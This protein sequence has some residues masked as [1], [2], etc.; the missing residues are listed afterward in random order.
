MQFGRFHGVILLLLGGLLLF[1]QVILTLEGLDRSAT[2]PRPTDQSAQAES[3]NGYAPLHRVEYVP[4]IVGVGLAAL[5][6]ILLVKRQKE[7]LDRFSQ[8]QAGHNS[9]TARSSR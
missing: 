2:Q 6:T 7:I 9:G 5:G 1:V 4:G 3:K 8:S